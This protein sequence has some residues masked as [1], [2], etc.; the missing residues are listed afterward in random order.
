MSIARIILVK[1]DSDDSGRMLMRYM[2]FRERLVPLI[3][4]AHW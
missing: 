2:G 1:E 4:G 3:R